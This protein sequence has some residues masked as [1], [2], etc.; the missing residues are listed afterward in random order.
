MSSARMLPKTELRDDG[1]FK[2]QRFGSTGDVTAASYAT[3]QLSKTSLL[4]QNPICARMIP[5]GIRM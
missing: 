3:Y 1:G 2:I 5:L 4:Q